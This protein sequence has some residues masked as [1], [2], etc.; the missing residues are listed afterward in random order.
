MAMAIL[1]TGKESAL[2]NA[3][4][5]TKLQDLEKLQPQVAQTLDG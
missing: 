3:K 5:T 4:N 1:A 2:A